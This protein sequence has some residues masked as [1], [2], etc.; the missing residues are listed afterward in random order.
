[1]K[2]WR[3]VAIVSLIVMLLG[4]IWVLLWLERHPRVKLGTWRV[5]NY[6]Y[7]PDRHTI[8]QGFSHERMPLY[9]NAVTK[10]SYPIDFYLVRVGWKVYQVSQDGR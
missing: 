7:R 5:M 2:W 6:R 3:R 10:Q 8:P 1:V 9:H 4:P